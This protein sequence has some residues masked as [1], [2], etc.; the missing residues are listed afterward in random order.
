MRRYTSTLYIVGA[1]V[2][3]L[4]FGLFGR[5]PLQLRWLQIQLQGIR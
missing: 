2:L 4:V 5:L 1:D 3:I